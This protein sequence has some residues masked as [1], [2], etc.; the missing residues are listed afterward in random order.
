MKASLRAQYK[1]D[2]VYQISFHFWNRSKPIFVRN[3]HS[4]SVVWLSWEMAFFCTRNIF[5]DLE[6]ILSLLVYQVEDQ[7]WY[8]RHRWNWKYCPNCKLLPRE[9]WDFCLHC[10]IWCLGVLV[11]RRRQGLA[12]FHYIFWLG[13]NC[14]V[15]HTL[16][17]F[18]DEDSCTQNQKQQPFGF[19]HYG[20]LYDH[21]FVG[22]GA[23][24]ECHH[25]L[26]H[27]NDSGTPRHQK[28]EQQWRISRN[29]E[30]E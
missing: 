16:G 11:L 19:L 10:S 20:S 30:L 25:D 13:G 21:L 23:S 12:S 29:E 22:T 24:V 2:T 7:V 27:R 18:I 9:L 14:G 6:W 28:R 8:S 4:M 3:I 5:P 17:C 1:L 15:L 26:Q